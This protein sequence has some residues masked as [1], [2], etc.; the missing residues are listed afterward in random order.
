MEPWRRDEDRQAADEFQ[1]RER[2]AGLPVGGWFE[3]VVEDPLLVDPLDALQCERRAGAVPE[4]P[5][6]AWAV[7]PFDTYS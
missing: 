3:Q 6:Q 4:Q 7:Q 2:E 1:R 5:F